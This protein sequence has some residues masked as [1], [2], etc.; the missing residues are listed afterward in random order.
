MKI[1]ITSMGADLDAQVD[2]RFGRAQY[3]II[4]DPDTME[5]EAIEN[6]GNEAAHGAGI[7]SGQLMSSRGVQAVITGSV[8]PNAHQTLSAAGIEMYQSAGGTVAQTIDDY[9][10]AKLKPISEI[11]PA[12]RG[13][14]GGGGRG[15]GLGPGR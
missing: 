9:K 4:I 11:G 1:A 13:M 6:Q 5:F 10:S 7:Q 2:P 12:H 15:R 14:G 8:G 3:F